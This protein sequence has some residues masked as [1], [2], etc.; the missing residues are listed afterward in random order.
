MLVKEFDYNK[1]QRVNLN[2]KS[3]LINLFFNN[4]EIATLV[5]SEPKT[6]LHIRINSLEPTVKESFYRMSH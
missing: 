2:T 4:F 6:I 5:I 1:M 3:D